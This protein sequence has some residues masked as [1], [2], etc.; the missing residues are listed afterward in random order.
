MVSV[1]TADNELR[2]T[3]TFRVVGDKIEKTPSAN[4]ARGAVRVARAD[5]GA[6]LAAILAGLATNE[7]LSIGR[8]K[9][10]LTEARI[11]P[12][13]RA[14]ADP[15]PGRIARALEFFAFDPAPGWLLID[16]DDKGQPPEVRA[17]V[18]ALGGPWPALVSLWPELAEA[19]RV[20]RPSASD[21]VTAPGCGELQSSSA[22]FFIR[23]ADMSRAKETVDRLHA[24]AWAAGLGFFIVA[25]KGGGGDK[26][27]LLS[28]SIVDTSVASP[29]RL[30]FEAPPILHPPVTRAARPTL[31]R[32]GRTLA[33]LPPLDPMVQALADAAMD[34]AERVLRPERIRAAKEH[35]DA[36]T[37]KV[38]RERGLPLPEAR[39]VVRSRI[40]SRIIQDDDILEGPRGELWRAGDLL[41]NPHGR[42]S[43]GLPD[44]DEGRD[45][46]A[47]TATLFLRPR[48]DRPEERP[49]IVSHAH[50]LR[51][52]YRFARY[53]PE[54]PEDDPTSPPPVAYPAF[55]ETDPHVGGKRHRE[56]IRGDVQHAIRRARARRALAAEY[57]AI[58]GEVPLPDL[59]GM[60]EAEKA[61]ARA[62]TA[63]RRRPLQRAAKARVAVRFGM[64]VQELREPGRRTL[65]SGA[66]GVGKTAA[67]LDALVHARGLVVL[68]LTPDH[69]KT[70]EAF[71]DFEAERAKAHEDKLTPPPAMIW[72]GRG[73]AQAQGSDV[74][75]CAFADQ[76][77]AAAAKHVNVR[78]AMCRPCPLREGCAY[79][80]QTQRV[81]DCGKSG[82][83]M[84]IFAPHDVGLF[85]LP[86]G[87]KP[88]LVIWDERPRDM[89]V[90]EKPLRVALD[91][92]GAP[93]KP[94]VDGLFRDTLFSAT[95]EAAAMADALAEM[96]EKGRP[97]QIAVRQALRDHAGQE[98]DFLRAKG[99][100]KASLTEAAGVLRQFE[101][102]ALEKA[103]AGAVAEGAAAGAWAIG[104]PGAEVAQIRKRLAAVLETDLTKS[105][106]VLRRVME[107]VALE[108]DA[109][110]PGLMAVSAV[111]DG[112]GPG[113]A[114]AWIAR[115][116][117][118]GRATPL[119]HLDG[120]GAPEVAERFFG[121]I[122]HEHIP[123]ERNAYVVQ[124]MTSQGERKPEKRRRWSRQSMTGKQANGEPIRAEAAA[125]LRRDLAEFAGRFRSGSL[126]VAY[127]D[128]VEL[129]RG[130]LPPE[131][132]T[133]HFAAL[134]GR[135]EW[136]DC[137]VGIVAG[138][139]LL[140][141]AD[142]EAKARALHA[143]DPQPLAT[144]PT[145][146]PYPLEPRRLRMRD[147][148]VKVAHV[149]YHPDPRCDA[150]LK[151][152]RD[153]EIAQALDRTRPIFNRRL[154]FILGEV[155]VDATV[156]EVVTWAE[157]RASRIATALDA[158]LLPLSS[159]EA[160]R[161][162]P[163][164]WPNRKAAQRDGRLQA[165]AEALTGPEAGGVW[166]GHFLNRI[167]IW[168]LSQAKNAVLVRYRPASTPGRGGHRAD[169]F[170]VVAA[171]PRDARAVVEKIAGPVEAF[172]VVRVLARAEPPR[173]ARRLPTEEA[174]MLAATLE[175]GGL[176]RPLAEAK[177]LAAEAPPVAAPDFPR[178]VQPEPAQVVPLRRTGTGG[179]GP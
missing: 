42:H 33:P 41:D 104:E 173:P 4:M 111:H 145:G 82:E 21:G 56:A 35:E 140:P 109:P 129:L 153:A 135:N 130:D 17:Q 74:R 50:G 106:R 105:A 160:T 139:P 44:P 108:M 114:V 168:E 123:V 159:S 16:Y 177:A 147:G 156:D 39:N 7:A 155:A 146:T 150:I 32:A 9:G 86:G 70:T 138:R 18:K 162:F 25:K 154:L 96:L 125:E 116:P 65:L 29:E 110:R 30:V 11:I 43:I 54:P 151:Q 76:A 22:H 91:E 165:L 78:A 45:Y 134:R 2:L 126:L 143:A 34:D 103:L 112:E 55:G 152:I 37:E 163:A 121:P 99:W 148:S 58:R 1:F 89:M 166:V 72:K 19:E 67:A 157:V 15:Q 90:P 113:E 48:P 124:V 57:E 95:A 28:R 172:A 61:Q 52:V 98:L 23:F 38:A 169:I 68:F 170:A 46:G 92:F 132:S 122:R 12:K 115:R 175:D 101:D 59:S 136:K 10:G 174:E 27:P 176:A 80:A 118:F 73:A 83:G 141:P 85:N 31:A 178:P 142:L 8:P 40:R 144:I 179:G 127:K 102:T 131:V 77:N 49:V 71:A 171:E 6:E 60:A 36:E 128:A 20:F 81:K 97:A 94:Q 63:A 84:V 93:R 107:A 88:D 24:R 3:K 47:T 117:S 137:P 164:L 100:T 133:A 64:T 120:T 51:K 66:Q 158:G 13:E 26:A 62:A 149:E 14:I 87:V 75:M 5:T 69:G 167:S 79:I 119:L 161:L 53:E